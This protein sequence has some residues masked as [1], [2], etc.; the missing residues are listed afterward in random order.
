MVAG[1]STRRMS[2]EMDVASS[3]LRTYVNNMLAKLG[4]CPRLEAVVLANRENLL[5][6]QTA[7]STARPGCLRQRLATDRLRRPSQRRSSRRQAAL[8]SGVP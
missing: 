2:R 8:V 7:W 3:T 6:D 5:G 1:Q 4:A